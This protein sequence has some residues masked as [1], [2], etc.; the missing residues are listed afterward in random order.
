MSRR[1][2]LRRRDFLKSG[3]A[4]G[5]GAAALGR[6]P[7][8]AEAAPGRPGAAGAPLVITSH[9][10]ATGADAMRQAWAILSGGGSALDAVERGANVIEADPN[11]HSVGLGGL[12]NLDGV[13]Q[14]DAS[15]MDG[16]TYSAGAVA[17]LEN[18]LHPSSVA[19]L[20]MERTDHVLLVGAGALAF[21]RSF[22]FEEV[23][24]LTPEAREIWL[25]WREQL[26][27]TDKYGPP[28]HLRARP[29]TSRSD[30][31]MQ[32]PAEYEHGTTNVLAVDAAGDVAGITTTSGMS[33][34]IP[35][36]IGDSPIIGAGL[37]V[38]NA[39]GAAGATGRGEDVI[40][41][42]ACYYIVLRMREGRSPQEAC[43]DAIEMIVDRYRAVGL[44]YVPG[45]KFV[46]IS[47]A[48]DVGCAQM[49]TDQPPKLTLHTA[50]GLTVVEGTAHHGP[51]R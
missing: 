8:L 51:A 45:E 44:D 37:Y 15:I 2:P 34:K 43:Q 24:L 13:V 5:A 38:D 41:S 18:I 30:A 50:S 20:V 31:R 1:S 33:W 4:L 19:R 11:D 10:N 21:A 14:L 25:R 48:G 27:P 46:A 16:R 22:G 47:K 7:G 42:C 35:G 17:G 23:E 49:G 39:V 29:G 32:A 9:S 6:F 36:R 40:K 26:A 3:L 28:E 12:P